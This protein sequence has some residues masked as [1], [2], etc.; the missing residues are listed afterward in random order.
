MIVPVNRLRLPWDIIL[1]PFPK[2]V[3]ILAL[4]KHETESKDTLNS[5]T[6]RACNMRGFNGTV[7]ICVQMTIF[8]S[9]SL[10]Y[11]GFI[12]R[13]EEKAVLWLNIWWDAPE[14]MT[15]VADVQDV[16]SAMLVTGL[17]LVNRFDESAVKAVY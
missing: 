15:I 12:C 10:I 13:R 9:P 2:D 1:L 6:Y 14:S 5:G 4:S 7:P 16:E 11:F 17:E 8:P 3:R